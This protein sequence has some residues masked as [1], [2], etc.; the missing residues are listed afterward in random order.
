MIWC[1]RIISSISGAKIYVDGEFRGVAPIEPF[2]TEAGPHAIQVEA[3]GEETLQLDAM[4]EPDKETRVMAR[5]GVEA[6]PDPGTA[7]E[8]TTLGSVLIGA[9]ATS[10][11]GAFV[12]H[13]AAF[14]AAA[15]ANAKYAEVQN[16]NADGKGLSDEARDAS[17][18]ARAFDDDAKNNQLVA[19]VGYGLA[20]TLVGVGTWIL[21]DDDSASE[22]RTADPETSWSPVLQPVTGGVFAGAQVRF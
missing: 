11:V 15:D 3:E 4:V 6:K 12:M 16:Y 10:A 7:G 13:L 22:P 20:A 9:G 17:E 1:F 2:A 14:E 5:F 18:A 21:L 19:F 8:K